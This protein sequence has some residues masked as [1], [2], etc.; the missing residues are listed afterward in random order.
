MNVYEATQ[1]RL[2]RIF[3]DF[4]NVYVSFSGGKDSGVLLN[5]CI[6]YI[7]RHHLNARLGVFHIDYEAQYEVTTQYVNETMDQNA[8]IIE[9][10]RCCVPFKVP[11]CTSMYQNYWRPWETSKQDIW[12]SSMPA[13][14]YTEKDFPFYSHKIWDYDFQERFSLWLHEK[15]LAKRTCCL[16]GI[17]TQ[18][19]LYRWWA[20]HN[21]RNYRNH[22]G[23]KWTKQ[24][25][26]NV[27]NAYPIYDW[28]TED[29]W[30]ANARFGWKYNRLYD[31]YY[32][33]GVPIDTMRVASPFLSAA[34]ESLKLYR[35]LEPHTW[36]KLIS[37]VNGVN[38]TGIYGG[39]TT[40]GWKSIS[41]PKGHTWKSYMYFLL[42]TLPERTRN[43]YL[44]K[45]TTS[46]KFWREK[47]GCLSDKTIQD[48]YNAGI[49]IE[50]GDTT[51][52][53]TE[54]KPVRMEYLDEIDISD[55]NLI[56]TYKRMCVCILKN[57]HLC[58]YMGFTMTK[59]E[60]ERR[61]AVMEKYNA[62]L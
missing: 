40:M 29:I 37:R 17:R 45:L 26:D 5:L 31:L 54:K 7:R 28:I 12:V 4:D 22:E 57:D 60:A 51:N 36:G 20:I 61:K 53:R 56:P 10:Y 47:G 15:K 48:L 55:F 1:E 33:A 38:F 41:L 52:Y 18:E 42:D 58:K 62:L 9:A 21:T 25:Y 19:S 44:S 50:V 11:T 23:L 43:N 34:Q 6:D 13:N 30:T 39:A 49:D 32:Q 35:V 14:S 2:A 27:F 46:M 24:V 8:D 3:T 59:N 16:V